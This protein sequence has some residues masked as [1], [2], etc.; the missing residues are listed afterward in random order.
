MSNPCPH[1]SDLARALRPSLL[2]L[3]ALL[4]ACAPRASLPVRVPAEEAAWFKFPAS[5]DASEQ[6]VL[7][8]TVAAAIQLA[9][10][11]FRPQGTK[12]PRG[13]DAV[14]ACLYQRQSFDV[15]AAPWKEDLVLVRFSLSPGACIEQG[16]V[17]DQGSTYAVDPRQG[18]IVAVQRP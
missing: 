8:A 3:C 15:Q 11:D 10:E 2:L 18:R 14:E 7:P 4:G 5:L 13:S 9:L 16:P 17:T 1:P 12:P 6:V